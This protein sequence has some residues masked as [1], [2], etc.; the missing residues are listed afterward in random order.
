MDTALKQIITVYTVINHPVERVWKLW[1]SPEDIVKWN[2][3]SDD[4]YTPKAE[5][6]LTE[7]GSF[8]CR[9][10]AKDGSMGFDFSGVYEKVTINKQIKYTLDDGRKVT[11]GFTALHDKTKIVETFESEA[12]HPFEAQRDGWQSILNNFKKYAESQKV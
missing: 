7:G 2:N 10:E 9:M 12:H 6:D 1:T 5:N 8:S 3:A 4:W 11:V